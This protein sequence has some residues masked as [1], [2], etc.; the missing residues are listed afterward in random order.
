LKQLFSQCA[1]RTGQAG[2]SLIEL[3]AVTAVMVLISAVL[4]TS[5]TRFG[6][7]VLLQNLAY[8]IG[9]S[10]RQAQVYGISVQR[11]G[12]NTY[13]AGYGV[14]FD[15]SSPANYVLFGD[16]VTV[17][18]LY[19]TGEAVETTNIQ[20][21]FKVKQIC[22]TPAGG[23]QTCAID[24][25]DILFKRPDPD[26]WISAKPT[27]GTMVSCVMNPGSACYSNAQIIVQSPRGDVSTVVV[28]QNG[29][30]TIQ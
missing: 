24:A 21:G 5:N 13:T 1:H 8:D 14:H 4:L 27:S 19:D 26:A 29:Q 7:K 22:A 12:T 2:F 30:I 10:I 9:L 28:D 25:I 11:F 6:G 18:G 23:S 17:N 3:L 15:L 20:N 16:A